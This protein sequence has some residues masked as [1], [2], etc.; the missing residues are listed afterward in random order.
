MHWM[1][2]CAHLSFV[3]TVIGEVTMS[4]LNKTSSD[5]ALQEL[6]LLKALLQL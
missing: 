5:S 4:T 2:V 6:H 3:Q 1:H